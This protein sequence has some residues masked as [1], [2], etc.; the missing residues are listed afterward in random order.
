M[1]HLTQ[2]TSFPRPFG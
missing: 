2:N 1:S